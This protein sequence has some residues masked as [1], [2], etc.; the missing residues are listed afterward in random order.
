M[1]TLELK[2]ITLRV[3]DWMVHRE[4]GYT[5]QIKKLYKSGKGDML[6]PYT[7]ENQA[8]WKGYELPKTIK[9]NMIAKH[10]KQQIYEPLR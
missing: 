4:L 1:K 9:A 6:I 3:N 5:A 7:T 2:Y 10:F 8:I